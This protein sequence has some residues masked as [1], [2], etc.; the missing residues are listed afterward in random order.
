MHRPAHDSKRRR[1]IG[2]SF[3]LLIPLA[4]AAVVALTSED[5]RWRL[6]VIGLRASGA[7]AG[8]RWSDLLVMLRPGSGYWLQPLTESRNPYAVIRNPLTRARDAQHG[9][10]LYRQ[11]CAGCHGADTA[12]GAAAPPLTGET[13]RHGASDW[14]RYTVIRDGVPGTAMPAHDLA[15]DEIWRIVAFLQSQSAPSAA[16]SAATPPHGAGTRV[17]TFADL[18][19][20]N[21]NPADWLTYSRTLDGQRYSPSAAISN[22]NVAALAV[23]WIHQ[24]PDATDSIEMTP[25]VRDGVMFVTWP[26]AHVAALDAATGHTIWRWTRKMPADVRACCGFVN[27]GVAILGDRLVVGT[28]DAHLIAIDARS[29]ALLW[30]VVVADYRDGYAITSAPLAIDDLVVTGSS[31]GDYPTRGFIAAFAA[32]SGEERWR[33]QTIPAPEEPGHDTWSGD[34]WRTG[35]A[36]TW[37]SG[38]YDP[39]LRL[40]Y[41]G[42][43]NPAPD[44]AADVRTGDNL[45]SNSLLA[46][47]VD[48]GRRVWH[49]QFTPG[50]DHDWDAVH[51]PVLADIEIGGFRRPVVLM[52]NRN[53]YYYVLDRRDGTFLKAVPFVRQT[54]AR[55]IL[56]SGRPVRLP[57][58]APS[59]RGTLVYPSVAGATNWWSPSFS[60]AS[61]LYY[62]PAMERGS[63][64]FRA[65]TVTARRGE[66]LLGSSNQGNPDEPFFTVVRALRPD[67]GEPVWEH[68]FEARRSFAMT[69]GLMSTAGR[70]VFASDLDR[71]L[72]LDSDTGAVLFSM[73][74]GGRIAAAPMAYEVHGRP[75]VAISAGAILIALTLP[76]PT[77]AAGD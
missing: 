40:L 23:A 68:R 29:G 75:Y 72:A 45:Y 66:M 5:A 53:G 22:A 6:E 24:F 43:G 31:G 28:L 15:R 59:E 30:D 64:Y 48:T 38:T 19:A 57:G 56:P 70:L 17:V 41:W 58:V 42:V 34:A 47:D 25:L 13:L 1:R 46:L 77:T 11:R 4:I 49:F 51:I 52:A 36:A 37:L 14:A 27:R 65:P 50:D 74:T 61:N 55:E 76:I 62:V 54:W 44:F 12:G 18:I 8:I 69:G 20:A 39:A 67:S 33:F 21:E 3:W 26:P 60:P 71:F 32:A 73:D 2:W 7:I 9:A 10:D 35:G 63:V 16:G